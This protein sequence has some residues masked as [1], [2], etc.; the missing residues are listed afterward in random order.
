MGYESIRV[1]MS[2]VENISL[3]SKT[4]ISHIFGL[5][6]LSHLVINKKKNLKD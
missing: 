3:G 2:I 6:E 5:M 1:V 4:A